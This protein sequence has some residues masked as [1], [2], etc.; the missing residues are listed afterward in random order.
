MQAPLA[1]ALPNHIWDRGLVS[2]EVVK[3][4]LEP[5]EALWDDHM[6]EDASSQ[7]NGKIQNIN[8]LFRIN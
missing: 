7:H 3:Q 1:Q 6:E 5:V 8:T 2:M 4:L